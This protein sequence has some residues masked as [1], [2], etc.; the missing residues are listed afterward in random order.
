MLAGAGQARAAGD[1]DARFFWGDSGGA[2]GVGVGW[3]ADI[4]RNQSVATGNKRP[5]ADC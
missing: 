1:L 3:G 2:L 4:D 5:E